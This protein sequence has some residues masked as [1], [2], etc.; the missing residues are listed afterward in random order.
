MGNDFQIK[1]P[2]VFKYVVG[3]MKGMKAKVNLREGAIPVFC[4]KAAQYL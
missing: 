4:Q 1:Y 3:T 2:S